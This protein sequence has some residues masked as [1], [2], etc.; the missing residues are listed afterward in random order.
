MTP[1]GAHRCW[2]RFGGDDLSRC[3][4]YN[5]RGKCSAGGCYTEPRCITD[6]PLRGWPRA[7]VMERAREVGA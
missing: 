3:D 6:S 1:L 5:G 7:R 4:Y 2:G